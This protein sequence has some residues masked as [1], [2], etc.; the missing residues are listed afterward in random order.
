MSIQ[1]SELM[2]TDIL[3]WPFMIIYFKR[4]IEKH[5]EHT[6]DLVLSGR[7]AIG[8]GASS[9]SSSGVDGPVELSCL[10]CCCCKNNKI[11]L[12]HLMINTDTKYFLISINCSLSESLNPRHFLIF[13]LLNP[14][15]STS[16]MRINIICINLNLLLLKIILAK[17][18]FILFFKNV[19]TRTKFVKI[20]KGW[21]SDIIEFLF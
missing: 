12:I 2:S 13:P 4:I 18:C 1:F 21:K 11:M 19:L 8:G 3:F 15:I 14:F 16:K 20:N 7:V 5:E 9:S 10:D 17:F 6:I